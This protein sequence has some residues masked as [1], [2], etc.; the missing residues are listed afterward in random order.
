MSDDLFSAENVTTRDRDAAHTWVPYDE[1]FARRVGYIIESADAVQ[2]TRAVGLV[3][4]TMGMNPYGAPTE[5]EARYIAD[6]VDQLLA[7][8]LAAAED[9]TLV[10]LDQ[11]EP[12]PDLGTAAAEEDVVEFNDYEPGPYLTAVLSPRGYREAVEK[13]GVQACLDDGLDVPEEIR[14]EFEP[15]AEDVEDDGLDDTP[16]E[17]EDTD[18][19]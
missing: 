15:A 13:F 14:A 1:D 5:T 11:P 6:N 12:N 2:V 7:A 4:D 8:A 10:P 17:S 9:G 3:T 16:A 19:D 18:E